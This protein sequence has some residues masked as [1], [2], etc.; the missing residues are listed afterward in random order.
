MNR[1]TLLGTLTSAGVAAL[2][3]CLGDD[4][5]SGDGN[6]TATG[7]ATA[8]ETSMSTP[9]PALSGADFTVTQRTDGTQADSASVSFSGTDVVVDGSIWGPNGCQTASLGSFTHNDGKLTVDIGVTERDD[10]GD[11]CSPAIVQIEYTATITFEH[12]TPD[13]VLVTHSRGNTTKDVTRASP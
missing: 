8:T 7:N 1:R 4:G 9:T 3:G 12:G 5:S 10:A 11:M 6:T 2:T 13:T